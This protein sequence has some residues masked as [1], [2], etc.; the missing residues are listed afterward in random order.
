MKNK[1]LVLGLSIS[2]LASFSA[3][4]QEKEGGDKFAERKA[5]MIAELN[6]EKSL[7]DASISCI[8]SA[9]KTEDM[10][11]CHEQRK[12]SMDSLRQAREAEHQKR[13]GERKAKLQQELQDIDQKMNEKSSTTKN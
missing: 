4:A 7:I 6:K 11:K 1:F 5:Q 9:A 10:K 12:S 8:N 13:M 2:M 3:N